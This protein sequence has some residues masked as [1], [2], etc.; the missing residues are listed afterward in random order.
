MYEQFI[1]LNRAAFEGR[2]FDGAYHALDGAL[3]CARDLQDADRL[4]AVE[5]TATEQLAWIDA[6]D[7]A[8]HHSTAAA[9]TRGHA[10]IFAT[11]AAQAHGRRVIVRGGRTDHA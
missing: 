10:S 6:H 2:H 7:P 9:K 5:A 1:A 3:V 11:L 8:Y 4:A